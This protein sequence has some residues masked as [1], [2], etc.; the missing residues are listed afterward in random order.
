MRFLF[1]LVFFCTAFCVNAQYFQYSQYN[2]T[3]QRINPAMVAASNYATA[4]LIYRNQSTGGEANL[5]SSMLSGAYPIFSRRTRKRWSGVGI[6]LLDDR[7]ADIF[8]TQEVGFSYAINI[9]PARFQTL[10]IGFKGLYQVKSINLDGLYTGSQYIPDRGFDEAIATGENLQFLRTQFFTFNTGVYWEQSDREENRLAYLGISLFDFNKPNDSFSGI[11]SDLSSTLIFTGG[12]RVYENKKIAV[13]PEIL[14]TRSAS[15][16][17]FNIGTTTS[18]ILQPLSAAY[19]ARIDIL[20]KYVVGSSGILGIQLH[21]ENFSIGCSYDFPVI[22]RNPGNHNA[23]E[24][25]LQI[26]KLV[27]PRFRRKTNSRIKSPQAKKQT[28]KRPTSKAPVVKSQPGNR[29]KPG[30][31]SQPVSD[32]VMNS[33]KPKADLKT[34]LQHKQDSVKMIA[35]AGKIQHEPL[36]VERITLHFHFEFNSSDLDEES[37]EYLNDLSIA[38]SE[39]QHLR[40]RLTGH[41]DNVGSAKFNQRLSLFRAN[42]IK[43][44]LVA[45]G[46]EPS[47]I[48]TEGRGMTEPLNGNKTEAQMAKNRRVDLV[49]FYED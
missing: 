42:S 13:L 43:D 47:R 23:L 18:Y 22:S 24:V 11:E 25:A 30:H 33:K 27:H 37:M 46:I 17:V 35:Q 9:V 32:S 8:Q 49:I 12:I 36:V 41:T 6:S 21:R 15:N 45:K 4:D 2:Y 28:A 38:L 34:R 40:I 1:T 10:S 29:S 48:T 44:Y 20:M 14:F 26:R 39:N 16:N 19:P 7:A 31:K 3:S 5:K